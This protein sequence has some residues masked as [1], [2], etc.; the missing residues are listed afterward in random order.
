MAD[1]KKSVISSVDPKEDIK[2][3]CTIIIKDDDLIGL[4]SGTANPQQL[5]MK[6]L[7]KVKGNIML[8]QKLDK[9]FKANAK[10]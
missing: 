5:F 9:L 3:D 6:G 10:L 7:L 8:A 2:A 1:L 4:A